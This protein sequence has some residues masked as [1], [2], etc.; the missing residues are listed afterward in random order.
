M[1]K[2]AH[3][4]KEKRLA[5]VI[6]TV[7]AFAALILA[8]VMLFAQRGRTFRFVGGSTIYYVG[9]E[10]YE[11]AGEPLIYNSK[12][13][14]PADDILRKCGYTTYYVPDMRALAVSNRDGKSYI[15]VNSSIITY[16]G[17]NIP[18]EDDAISV[19]NLMYI[20]TDMLAQFTDS[21]IEFEGTLKET[22]VIDQ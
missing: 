20:T 6:L 1:K 2:V 4:S 9:S 8:M 10:V 7:A 3:R 16:E 22:T 12:K 15:Y 11:L 13:Y 18:F 5:A 14:V 17:E 21:R 19:N